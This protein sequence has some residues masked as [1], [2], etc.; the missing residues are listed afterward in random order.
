MASTNVKL[1]TFTYPQ[2]NGRSRQSIE[3]YRPSFTC[4]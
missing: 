1:S 2:G 4:L 3:R